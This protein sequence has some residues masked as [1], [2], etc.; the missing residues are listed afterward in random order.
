[1]QYTTFKNIAKKFRPDIKVSQHGDFCTNDSKT[2]LGIIFIKNGRESRVYDYS[3]SYATVLS[4]LGVNVVTIETYNTIKN[5]EIAK[6][7]EKIEQLYKDKADGNTW[8]YDMFGGSIN[9]TIKE[10]KQELV[11]YKK[12]IEDVDNHKVIYEGDYV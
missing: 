2:T 11:K 4:K 10:A 5:H 1:M 7:E 12:F 3:G 9:D 8:L 6:V